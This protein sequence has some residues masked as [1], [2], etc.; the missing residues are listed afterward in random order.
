MAYKSPT[1][2]PRLFVSANNLRDPDIF[3]YEFRCNEVVL[4]TGTA[5]SLRVVDV[6]FYAFK[7]RQ[8]TDDA[9]S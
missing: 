7:A 4:E 9:Q 2:T 5:R 8:E 3:D 1:T 6:L